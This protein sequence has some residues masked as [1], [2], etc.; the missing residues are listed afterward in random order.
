MERSLNVTLLLI[1]TAVIMC[2]IVGCKSNHVKPIKWEKPGDEL[3]GEWVWVK[4]TIYHPKKTFEATDYGN[5]ISN[6]S[7]LK[8][9]TSITFKHDGSTEIN[10][11]ISN[12]KKNI[13]GKWSVSNDTLKIIFKKDGGIANLKYKVAGNRLTIEH[14]L[15]IKT[16]EEYERE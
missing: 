7:G 5:F 16:I 2:F 9:S 4:G 8:A 6:N 1:F 12:L 15:K 3:V 10:S 14:L 13:L 11:E